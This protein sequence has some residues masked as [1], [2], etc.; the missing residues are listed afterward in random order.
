MPD[1]ANAKCAARRIFFPSRQQIFP[2]NLRFGWAIP[3]E[4][5]LV[6]LWAKKPVRL[7]P[8]VPFEKFR[9]PGYEEIALAAATEHLKV[10]ASMEAVGAF[11]G[12][13]HEDAA[14]ISC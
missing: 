1:G 14:F 6:S 9:S 10:I 2:V 12:H 7:Q 4:V 3:P 11:R 13:V 8:P 5:T